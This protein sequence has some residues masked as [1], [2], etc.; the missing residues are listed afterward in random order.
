LDMAPLQLVGT[1][2]L[3]FGCLLPGYVNS[4]SHFHER[5]NLARTKGLTLS[6][7]VYEV[8]K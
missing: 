1:S 2:H 8:M 4:P 3:P 7:R 6:K 5:F